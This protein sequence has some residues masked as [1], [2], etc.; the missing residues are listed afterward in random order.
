MADLEAYLQEKSP[1]LHKKYIEITE[2]CKKLWGNTKLDWF[3]DHTPTHSARLVRYLNQ[4]LAPIEQTDR[5]LTPDECFVLLSSCYLHD[6]G[7]QDMRRTGKT[8]EKLSD[9]EFRR[10]RDEHAQRSFD[11]IKEGTLRPDGINSVDI[12]LE[13][14]DAW[15]RAM[16]W[17]SKAHSTRYY[18]ESVE[19][20]TSDPL[21]VRGNRLRGPFLCALLLLADELDLTD[22]RVDFSQAV[23]KD[24]SPE[25][26]LHWY[27]HHYIELVEIVNQQVSITYRIHEELKPYADLLKAHVAGKLNGQF[28]RC[29]PIYREAAG[30]GGLEL[31]TAKVNMSEGFKRP[32]PAEVLE[33]LKKEAEP[34]ESE[35]PEDNAPGTA[36][37]V[38]PP[39]PS[40]LF[41]GRAD[42]LEMLEGL[43]SDHRVSMITGIGGTGKSQLV[44]Q[45]VAERTHFPSDSVYWFDLAYKQT[46]DDIAIALGFSE[47]LK[48][49]RMT[50][51]EK[52]A[53]LA[54]IIDRTKCLVV[55]DNI[56]DCQDEALGHTIHQSVDRLS[57][58]RILLVGKS[59]PKFVVVLEPRLVIKQ[60]NGLKDDG[61]AYARKLRTQWEIDI[62]DAETVDM[63]REVG[64]HPMAIEVAFNVL[65]YEEKPRDLLQKIV[66]FTKD[67]DDPEALSAR[68]LSELHS[69][70]TKPQRDLAYRLSVFRRPFPR[71]AAGFAAG[72]EDWQADF[73]ELVDKLMFRKEDDEFHMHQLVRAFCN[74][75]LSDTAGTSAH[76]GAAAFYKSLRGNGANIAFEHE[77]VHHLL[78][79]GSRDEAVDILVSH[80]RDFLIWGHTSALLDMLA[81]VDNRGGLTDRLLNLRGRLY[82]S[83]A[84]YDLA[85]VDL[86]A[87]RLSPDP[88]C[89]AE[90]LYRKGAIWLAR[91]DLQKAEGL[92][93]ASLSIAQE[94]HIPRLIAYNTDAFGRMAE[95]QGRLHDAMARFQSAYAILQ[96]VPQRDEHDIGVAIRN[97][98]AVLHGQG[99]LKRAMEKYEES[100]QIR[101]AV[102]DQL[103]IG[104]CV[105]DI[106]S[107]L[108]DQGNLDGA[109][110]KYEESLQIRI[111]VGDQSGIAGCTRAVGTI[112]EAKAD[113]EGAMA[114][115]EESVAI[116][117]AI[118]EQ[119]G[120]GA[121]ICSIGRVL[122]RRGDLQGAMARYEQSVA[123]YTAMGNTLN[124]ARS[125][126]NMATVHDKLNEPGLAANRFAESCGLYRDAGAL[127]DLAFTLRNLAR[128]YENAGEHE[129]AI[130]PF[131]EAEALYRRLER[132][133]ETEETANE[134]CRARQSIGFQEFR[135]LAEA[136]YGVLPDDLKPFSH[137]HEYI[138][139]TT[140]RKETR[141]GRND[142]C[143]CGSGKKYK[144]CCLG[145]D[146]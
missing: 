137:Y 31:A 97:I 71:S 114:K 28:H 92:L 18:D 16:A 141:A 115:Y 125:L 77:I 55:I 69:H 121:G 34:D 86:D 90:A 91:C 10:I 116:Y 61:I 35:S 52:G 79:G 11:M 40:S 21:I 122:Q 109:M 89:R 131:L 144:R 70:A 120:I 101:I 26:L 5:F 59:R 110:A 135:R 99:D 80:G 117:S 130:R 65:R 38:R 3:T 19:Y 9:E 113:L 118:G 62:T 129:Y 104:S 30:I 84:Q 94:H 139:D 54:D 85:M 36:I 6:I 102:G 63:C 37:R 93:E 67:S 58:S 98:G 7:M 76:V 133:R 87:A 95:G 17:V 132:E 48:K 112:L 15:A 2:A 20:I 56:Q 143:P 22:E 146:A 44:A 45:Y 68:L 25:T 46:A 42:E 111:T 8:E 82:E 49:E 12:R 50:A 60:I 29:S 140:L 39:Q 47:M 124:V 73:K 23:L 53:N 13:G 78:R 81:E 134:I 4:M 127:G 64:N 57:R 108:Q 74:D 103:G 27:V 33:L 107:I 41:T 136:A 72:R 14:Q 142:P 75:K 106:G 119:S 51:Q 43:V 138:A 105:H 126:N 66:E 123:I 88:E 100:L 83:L 1:D 96:N 32:M 128:C 24:L 145:K